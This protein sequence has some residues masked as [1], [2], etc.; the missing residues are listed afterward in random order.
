MGQ[1]VAVSEEIEMKLGEDFLKGEHESVPI[2]SS[3]SC[4]DEES[5]H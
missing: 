5:A 1:H 2:A 3:T 4:E